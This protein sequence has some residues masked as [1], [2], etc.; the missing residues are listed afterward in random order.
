MVETP[1]IESGLSAGTDTN[2]YIVQFLT[3][4]L[5]EFKNAIE[6]LGGFV[7]QYV[8][9]FAYVVEMDENVKSQ[10]ESLPYVRWIGPY[11]PAY[12][13]EEFMIDNY[14]NAQQMYPLQRYNIQVNNVDKKE[15]L[16]NKIENLGGIVNKADAGKI[17][18]EATLTPEQLFEVARLDEVNFIDRW[19]EYEVD[20]DNGREIGG[21]NYIETVGNYTGNDVRGEI[22]DTGVNPNH[23]DF[24]LNPLIVHGPSCGSDSHGTACCGIN[25]GTG[26]GNPDARGL[27]PNGQGIIADYSIIGL[28]GTNRYLHSGELVEDPYYAV[29]QTASVGSGRTTEYTTVSADSD[30]A[31]FDFD[32]VHCQSQSNAGNQMSRPQAWAKN[33]VSGGAVYHYDTLDKS[34]DMWNSGASTGPASDGRIKP[35]F[36]FFYDDILTVGWPGNDAYT[37]G[38]GGT[39]G[40]TPMTAGHFGL[41]FEM[42]DDGIFGNPVDPYGSVFENKAHFSTAKAMMINTAE[43]YPFSGTSHDKTRMH[44]QAVR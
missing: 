27:I 20:M 14:E 42:W 19:A 15:I 8:A 16:A 9:Q 29:F 6:S 41:F 40:A 7:Y 28:E 30:A 35:T 36:C 3:Q 34:D 32:L 37:T 38:F 2:L 12:R 17:L 26:T 5:E 23:V 22:F 24:Q 21:A 10:V 11:H 33:M 13:L 43:Q 31:V 25:F 4:P 1:T 18:V 44:R 39:S